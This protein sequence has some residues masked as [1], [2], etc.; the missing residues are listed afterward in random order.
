VD[1]LPNDSGVLINRI[2]SIGIAN[3]ISQNLQN[4]LNI[5]IGDEILDHWQKTRR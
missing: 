2:V 5:V 4:F 1:F 3:I